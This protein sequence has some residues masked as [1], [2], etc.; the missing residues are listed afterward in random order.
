MPDEKY[1]YPNTDILINRFNIKD[2]E[3]LHE[4]ELGCSA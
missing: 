4:A 3:M 2:P 1:C